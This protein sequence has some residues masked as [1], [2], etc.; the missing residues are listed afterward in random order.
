L[1]ALVVANHAGIMEAGRDGLEATE[2]VGDEEAGS[3][4]GDVT[5]NL[6]LAEEDVDEGHTT[7]EESATGFDDKVGGGFTDGFS[8]EAESFIVHDFIATGDNTAKCDIV[9]GA[10]N[11]ELIFKDKAIDGLDLNL[12][13]GEDQLGAEH[14]RGDDAID[15]FVLGK[16]VP[17]LAEFG[18]E[19]NCAEVVGEDVSGHNLF[20]LVFCFVSSS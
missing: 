10:D 9:V 16:T 5:V 6:E 3:G 7:V 8:E 14:G 20:L 12:F 17:S 18:R 13:G 15:L 11:L 1:T 19:A 2:A 4:G